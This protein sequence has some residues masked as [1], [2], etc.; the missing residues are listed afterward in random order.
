[1]FTNTAVFFIIPNS[2]A[3]KRCL[4]SGVRGVWTEITSDRRRS[5]SNSTGT[6]PVS[7]SST[8]FRV[9][10][11]YRM[12][13][14]NPTARLATAVPIR[15]APTRPRVEPCM[16]MPLWRSGAQPLNCPP[17][18]NRSDVTIHRAAERMSPQVRSAV[19]SVS[20]PGVL[21]TVI[22]SSRAVSRSMLLYPT[23][24]W[25]TILRSGFERRIP[26]S[27]VSLRRE[28][29]PSHPFMPWMISSRVAGMKGWGCMRY[30]IPALWRTL[31]PSS[32][33]VRVMKT[34]CDMAEGRPG[35]LFEC[36]PLK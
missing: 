35:A 21:V 11:W 26:S 15:P 12:S 34:L 27:M 28:I 33:M 29:R 24:Y 13:I 4:V 2:R 17:R 32:G 31:S 6:A 25:L 14:P 16:S 9:R 1:M 7:S 3:V 19:A 18:V 36:F 30:R 20:T 10:L 22:P 5:S 8:G 23:A